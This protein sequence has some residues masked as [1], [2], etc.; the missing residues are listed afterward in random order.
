MGPV[1]VRNKVNVDIFL[2]GFQGLGDHQRAEIGTTNSDIDNI[3]DCF[4]C[5]AGVLATVDSV[6][7]CFHLCLDVPSVLLQSDFLPG[8]G[9]HRA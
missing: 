8:R 4:A 5:V 2:E 3:C 6:T 9:E 1:N 7:E